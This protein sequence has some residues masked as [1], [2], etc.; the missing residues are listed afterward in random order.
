[1][2]KARAGEPRRRYVPAAT[3][4]G[5]PHIIVD[6]APR[7]GTVCTLSHWP[8]TPTP[9]KLWHDVSAGIVMAALARRELPGDV[10]A[11]SID[12]YDADG[13][14]ALALLCVEGLAAA[15]GS[16]LVEAAQVGD[17]DVVTGRDAAVVAFAVQALGDVARAAA[18]LGVAPPDGEVTD[19]TA[20]AATEAL[21]I[22]PGLVEDPERYRALGADEAAAFDAS[23]GAVSEGWASI[24]ERP[25]HDLAIVRVDVTHPR[26]PEA[27]WGGAPLHRA[28]VHSATPRLRVATVAGGGV[29]VRYRYESWV[30]LQRRRPRRRVDLSALAAEL[31]RSET[32]GGRWVFDGA[33]AITGALH[34][35]PGAR[36]TLDPEHVVDEVCETLEVLD[37]GPPAWD[38]YAG[39]VRG[40]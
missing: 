27:A 6:G 13:V 39:A 33:G 36:S 4:D 26:A 19:A 14:L 5:R 35:A 22:L 9:E 20:W 37:A 12:H 25:E 18:V 34:L 23:W 8:G 29:E 2:A 1:V 38:P 16:F 30:R 3:L 28:A 7:P 31:T 21:R 17:F 32:S 10:E 24:E 40:G 15:H 11:V